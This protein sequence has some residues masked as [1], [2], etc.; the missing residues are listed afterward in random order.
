MNEGSEWPGVLGMGNVELVTDLE[1]PMVVQ[2][3]S[4]EEVIPGKVMPYL[5]IGNLAPGIGRN[6]RS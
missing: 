4:E 3:P 5:V 1:E 2:E 6:W